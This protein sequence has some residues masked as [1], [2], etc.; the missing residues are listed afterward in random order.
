MNRVR[1]ED[2]T[3]EEYKHNLVMEEF[4]RR[5]YLKGRFIKVNKGNK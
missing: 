5:V 4:Q 1:S 2:E 3:Y